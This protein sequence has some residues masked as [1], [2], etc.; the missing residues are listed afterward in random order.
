[1][2]FKLA[3]SSKNGSYQTGLCAG[4]EFCV[5][6]AHNCCSSYKLLLVVYSNAWWFPF[7]ET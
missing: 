7:T 5:P 4:G 6:P 1:V 2:C 3:L